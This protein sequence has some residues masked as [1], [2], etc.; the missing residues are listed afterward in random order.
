MS[1]TAM[2]RLAVAPAPAPPEKEPDRDVKGSAPRDTAIGRIATFIPSEILA[3]YATMYG[4]IR[5]TSEDQQTQWTLFSIAVALLALHVWLTWL[6][7]YKKTETR[8]ARG[9]SWTVFLMALLAFSAYAATLP[10]NPFLH[11][12]PNAT[13][14]GAVAAG[15]LAVFLPMVGDFF[16]ISNKPKDENNPAKPPEQ[17]EPENEHD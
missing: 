7:E 17:Q 5:P 3:L 10:D 14:Y 13:A 6:L 11:L 15:I 2:M 8:P 16:G 9:R 4:T 12:N 1:V